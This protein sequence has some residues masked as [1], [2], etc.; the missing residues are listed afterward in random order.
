M[1][2]SFVFYRS[3]YEVF[4]DL[5]KKD[6]LIIFDAICEYA[7]NDVE[8]TL[9]GAPAIVFKL[10]KPQ[11]DANNRRYENGKK[12][13]RPKANLDETKPKPKQ[14]QNVTTTEPNVNVNVNVNDNVNVNAPGSGNT[15]VWSLS[16]SVLTYLNQKAGTDYKTDSVENVKLISDLSHNG[17][18]EADMKRVVDVKCADWLGNPVVERYLRP[19]TLFGSKFAEYL[20][21]PMPEGVKKQKRAE[22]RSADNA[23]RVEAFRGE[24]TMLQ[25]RIKSADTATRIQLREREAWL[26]DE[27]ARLTG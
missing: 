24:L 6:K 16:F 27:I 12:G 13:G 8:P 1:R 14:N 5:S 26:Q 22:K 25:D 3:F 10:L 18:T 20:S 2:N 11:V 17:Y 4:S 9:N 19:S 15:D 23:E 7:L 21:Q